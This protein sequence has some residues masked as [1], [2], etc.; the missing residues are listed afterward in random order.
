MNQI[1]GGNQPVVDGEWRMSVLFRCFSWFL[2]RDDVA[3]IVSLDF[4][5]RYSCPLKIHEVFHNVDW[6]QSF[7]RFNR[8][9][10]VFSQSAFQ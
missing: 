7:N 6:P 9:C 4:S 10:P 1:F 5:L 8:L 3:T 2:S